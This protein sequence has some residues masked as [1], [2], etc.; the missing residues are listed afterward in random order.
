MNHLNNKDKGAFIAI[1]KGTDIL[2]KNKGLVQLKIAEDYFRKAIE[3]KPDSSLA[4]F[5]LAIALIKQ[6]N[7]QGAIENLNISITYKPDYE[8]A[9][10]LLKR[11][12][13][14]PP[15]KPVLPDRILYPILEE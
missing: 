1:V 15:P 12:L 10:L 2:V 13:S 4:Y 9:K 5:Q 7:N 11:L 8:R 14:L 6:G 3:L